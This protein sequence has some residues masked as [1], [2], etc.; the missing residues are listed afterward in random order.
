M[1]RWAS[2]GL[3]GVGFLC[4]VLLDKE[5]VELHGEG[6]V[7]R[8]GPCRADMEVNLLP[9]MSADDDTMLKDLFTYLTRPNSR[10]CG[11][12][13]KFGGMAMRLEDGERLEIFEDG[14]KYACLDPEFSLRS[15]DQCL[16]YSFGISDDWSFDWDMEAFGCSVYA[17]DPSIKTMSGH[18][19]GSIFFLRYGIGQYD[20]KDD[21]DFRLRTLDTFVK[22][23][24]HTQR[25]IHYLKMDTEGAEWEVLRQQTGRGRDSV[26][27]K[28]VQQMGLELHFSDHRPVRRHVPFY[29]QTYETFLRLQEMGFYLFSYE[30]NFS[31]K[32]D[33]PVP[34]L[35]ENLTDAMEVVWVKTKCAGGAGGLDDDRGGES[36]ALR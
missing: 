13:L 1:L 20:Y 10:T 19:N 31:L 28:N 2:V 33:M 9:P 27:W 35:R 14:H 4:L 18:Q 25:T 34:G 5:T 23:L 12:V 16:V 7:D 36:T 11:R 15:T 32:P 30:P 8:S 22:R 3:V 29:R 17:F 24:K 21:H 26:L 6:E